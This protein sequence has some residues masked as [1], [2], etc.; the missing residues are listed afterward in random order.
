MTIIIHKII[1]NF[2]HFGFFEHILY[3]IFTSLD[4]VSCVDTEQ[5]IQ[6]IRDI[7]QG[8][9]G[10]L[11]TIFEDSIEGIAAEMFQAGVITMFVVQ[12]PTFEKII[13]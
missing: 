2:S 6:C 7:I 5:V 9:Y 12:N 10:S 3:N 1:I 11:R 13:I 4:S 8:N